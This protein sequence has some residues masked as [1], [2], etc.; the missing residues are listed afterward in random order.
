M[1]E[2]Q[3]T[4]QIEDKNLNYLKCENKLGVCNR[5]LV[6]FRVKVSK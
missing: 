6:V 4:F 5:C 2:T 3:K 1:S